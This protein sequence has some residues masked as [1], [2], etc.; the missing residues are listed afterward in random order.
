MDDS[1]KK[2][3]VEDWVFQIADASDLIFPEDQGDF[4]PETPRVTFPNFREFGRHHAR[5]DGV[6][7]SSSS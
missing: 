3:Y 2:A 4:I 5:A 7:R 6:C 1:F